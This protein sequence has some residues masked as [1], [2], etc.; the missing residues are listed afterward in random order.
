[1]T[2][3]A[4]HKKRSRKTYQKNPAFKSKDCAMHLSIFDLLFGNGKSKK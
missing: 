2:C 3:K 4:N 1:M